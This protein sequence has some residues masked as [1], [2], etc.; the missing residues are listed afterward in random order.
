M[1]RHPRSMRGSVAP[2]EGRATE[3]P[4][5]QKLNGRHL[6]QSSLRAD[7][8][9][10]RAPHGGVEHSESLHAK[11]VEHRINIPRAGR[12]RWLVCLRFCRLQNVS[13][14]RVDSEWIP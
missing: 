7:C 3:L 9:K 14:N 12:G 11:K 4:A 2:E 5:F 8:V 6:S 10:A 1:Q 13:T